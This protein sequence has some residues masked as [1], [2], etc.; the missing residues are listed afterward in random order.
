MAILSLIYL[1][2]VVI[3]HSFWY[4]YQRVFFNHLFLTINYEMSTA[5]SETNGLF[6][7]G[8]P[9]SIANLLIII[10]TWGIPPIIPSPL[11]LNTLQGGAPQ[12]CLLVY[13]PINY[14]Y[15]TYKP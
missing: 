7:W 14:R 13:N 2:K 6:N 4:V 9:L 3:F 15:I 1:L 11:V 10:L 12:L 8:V 5:D